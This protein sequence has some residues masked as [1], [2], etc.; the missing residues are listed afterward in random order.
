MS[1]QKTM[2][3]LDLFFSFVKTVTPCL[4]MALH[5]GVVKLIKY[6]CLL[7]EVKQLKDRQM[8]KFP[9]T[10]YTESSTNHLCGH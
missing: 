3:K 1:Y 5:L 8:A 6:N 4:Q 10:E 2:N 7:S 9:S